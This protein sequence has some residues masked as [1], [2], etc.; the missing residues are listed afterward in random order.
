MMP[1]Q[2][3]SQSTSTSSP[4]PKTRDEA[5]AVDVVEYVDFEPVTENS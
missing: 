1:L 5:A 3:M 2:S 4:P